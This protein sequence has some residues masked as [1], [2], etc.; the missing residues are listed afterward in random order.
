MLFKSPHFRFNGKSS[1]DFQLRIC[2]VGNGSETHAFGVER[3]VNAETT[4]G[5]V[6]TFKDFSYNNS[7]FDITLVKTNGHQ[8]LPFTKDER[9]EIIQWLFQ[10]GFKP[11]ISEDDESKIY[12]VLFTAGSRYY[13]GLDQGYLNLTIQLNAPC[14]FSPVLTHFYQVEGTQLIELENKTNVEPFT[15]PDIEFWLNGETTDLMIENLTT[16]DVTSFSNLRK[17]THLYCYN[18]GMKQLQCINNATYNARPSFNNKWIKLAQG[19][20]LL[21]ITSP[22]AHVK[23]I[24]QTKLALD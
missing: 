7:S 19:R 17:E 4:V 20:N 1:R 24:S 15:Y 14:A 22:H 2:E 8:V 11:F 3:S 5:M 10:D 12:Y 21:R 18:E 23:L 16:G 6:S 9:F 13:N